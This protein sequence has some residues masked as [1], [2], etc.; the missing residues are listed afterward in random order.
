[1]QL[2][3]TRPEWFNSN[4]MRILHQAFKFAVK[5]FGLEKHS[6]AV[7]LRFEVK[8]RDN[9]A[10]FVDNETR[11]PICMSIG[12]FPL[13]RTINALFHEM[14]HVKQRVRG[15]LEVS[16]EQ[17]RARFMG[18]YF[19][20]RDLNDNRL[21]TPEEIEKYKNL[22]WEKEAFDKQAEL[23]HGFAQVVSQ[24]D[25]HYLRDTIWQEAA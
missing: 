10:A 25:Y 8:L 21:H 2:V 13:L 1:M 12:K 15:E 16:G 11:D 22:P 23:T 24:V 14:T 9:G 20:E 5:H 6:E 19:Y 7:L 17:R 4:D 3:T 18:R